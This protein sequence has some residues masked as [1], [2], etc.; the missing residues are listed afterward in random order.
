MEKKP[1]YPT[2]HQKYALALEDLVDFDSS[3]KSLKR[4]MYSCEDVLDRDDLEVLRDRFERCDEMD[5]FNWFSDK[6]CAY[7]FAWAMHNMRRNFRNNT[8]IVLYVRD[9][10]WNR[11]FQRRLEKC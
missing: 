8:L 1:S 2:V 9:S 11:S 10:E 4:S 5:A 6:M 3:V 7:D